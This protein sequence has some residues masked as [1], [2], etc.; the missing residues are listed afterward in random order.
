MSLISKKPE[1]LIHIYYTYLSQENHETLLEH[2]L[3]KFPADYQDKIRRF[4]RWEDAQLSLLGRILLYKGV[5]E[6]YK[7]NPY[8]KILKHTEYNKPYFDD[9]KIQFNISHSGEIVVC[10]LSDE[11]ELGIDIEIVTDVTLTDFRSQLTENEWKKI[12]LSANK[13]DS[14]FEYWAQKEA[15]IKTHGHGLSIPLTSFEILENKTVIENEDYYLQQ[16]RIDKKYK[17]Y[18]AL[19]TNNSSITLKK[20]NTNEI[21]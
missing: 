4:R 9:D 12:T 11:H 17:C 5:E 8:N 19:K 21:L 18:L 7:Q 13:N 6:I 10:A 14:F 1:A 2:Y 15:V 20:Y 16:L 3:P